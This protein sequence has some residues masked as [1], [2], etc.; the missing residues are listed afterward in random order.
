ML[1][2]R[3]VGGVTGRMAPTIKADVTTAT[4]IENAY[5][6]LFDKMAIAESA[7][8]STFI[9]GGG[10]ALLRKNMLSVIPINCGATDSNI[11]LAIIKRGYRY[12]YL[13]Q[14]F[15]EEHVSTTLRGQIHQKIR[16]GSRLIQSIILNRDILFCEKLKSFRS[17]LQIYEKIVW[18][19]GV[20]G[21]RQLYFWKI[22]D[23][24]K[25]LMI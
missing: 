20:S 17:S 8:Y 22:I 3:E 14:T 25:I 16:R 12:L 4:Y 21:Q 5:S 11:A 7:L 1:H 19:A 24:D 15:S 9:V 13:P 6:S 23:A 10:F 18:L 2:F